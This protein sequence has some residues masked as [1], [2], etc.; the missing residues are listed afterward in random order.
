MINLGNVSFRTKYESES[1]N[2]KLVLT[3]NAKQNLRLK[4][5]GK[6]KLAQFLSLPEPDFE[7]Y[8]WQV[9]N[10]PLFDILR[11]K[12]RVLKYRKFSG[13]ITT[14][15]MKLQADIVEEQNRT[16][17]D[18]LLSDPTVFPLL[19]KIGKSI[20]EK[21]FLEIL[22]GRKNINEV[23]VKYELSSVEKDS[24]KQ[25][26]DKFHLDQLVN[27]DFTPALSHS[28]PFFLIAGFDWDGDN[29][30]I[31]PVKKQ[32]YLVKGRYNIDYTR[33]EKLIARGTIEKQDIGKITKL[34]RKLDMINQRITTIY[35][36]LHHLKQIQSTFFKS[37]TT[38]DL[39]S[40]TQSDLARNL[41]LHPSTVSRAIAGKSILTPQGKEK[42]IKF[43]FSR[44]WLKNLVKK[45]ILEEEEAI[46]KG[47]LISPLRDE[48]ICRRIAEDYK[49]NLSRRSIAKYR[50]MLNI[51]F[52]RQRGVKGSGL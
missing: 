36:I 39:I 25:F 16:E 13:V 33:F 3:Q 42:T 17:M 48:Q 20:G 27:P 35:Q 4:L 10:D 50:K 24:F 22:A 32:N 40:S 45:T 44:K 29:L 11:E 37:G 21:V 23:A 7:S 19:E 49:V 52:F 28:I 31:Y 47:V 18:E 41:N 30:M 14:N 38:L 12:Y 26:L 2:Q 15:T 34:F 46:E 43:F 8:I 6:I 51:P 1:M 9:E 5:M